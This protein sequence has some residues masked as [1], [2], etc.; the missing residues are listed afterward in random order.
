[1]QKFWNVVNVIFDWIMNIVFAAILF[2]GGAYVIKNI[3]F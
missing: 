2:G 1:M 3:F